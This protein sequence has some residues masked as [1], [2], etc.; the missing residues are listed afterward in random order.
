MTM[1]QI[2]VVLNLVVEEIHQTSEKDS[3]ANNPL[4]QF[5]FVLRSNEDDCKQPSQKIIVVHCLTSFPGQV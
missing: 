5:I 1:T 4:L 2:L 3:I